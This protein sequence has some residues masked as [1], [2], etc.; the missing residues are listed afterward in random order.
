MLR[1]DAAWLVEYYR[2]EPAARPGQPYSLLDGSG[3]FRVVQLE[4]PF[5]LQQ[6]LPMELDLPYDEA[7]TRLAGYDPA[8]RT[9]TVQ[10]ALYSDGLKSNYAMERL[11]EMY[12]AEYG[13]RLPP[14]SDGR[15]SN[16]IGTAAVIFTPAG[17]YLP[18]RAKGQ[19]V[20]PSGYHCTGAGEALWNGDAQ[21]FD[22]IFTENIY[23]ELEEEVVIEAI[24]DV[25][26]CEEG[27]RGTDLGVLGH[28]S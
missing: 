19:A 15:L 27:K 24:K 17:P 14:L 5:R 20:Y 7:V 4:E 23:K 13:S 22:E 18:R 21:S 16:A 12:R 10:K 1:Y 25:R 3:P 26:A 2:E 28:N 9:L 8:T 11:R 6:V